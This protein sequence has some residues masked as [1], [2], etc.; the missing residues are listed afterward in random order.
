MNISVICQ[1]STHVNIVTPHTHALLQGEY[2][3]DMLFES[4]VNVIASV[5]CTESTC[6]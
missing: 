3:S 5:N 2:F 1:D 6:V 4:V